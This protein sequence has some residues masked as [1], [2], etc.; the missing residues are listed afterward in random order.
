VEEIRGY[1]VGY[2]AN[3]VRHAGKRDQEPELA[4]QKHRTSQTQGYFDRPMAELRA[5]ARRQLQVEALTW[6]GMPADLAEREV[7]FRAEQTWQLVRRNPV[8]A[9]SPAGGDLEQLLGELV[10][11]EARSDGKSLS[12]REAAT[13]SPP[14]PPPMPVEL[15]AAAAEGIRPSRAV[16]WVVGRASA[17]RAGWPPASP[18]PMSAVPR[19]GQDASTPPGASFCPLPLLEVPDVLAVPPPP[20]R[21]P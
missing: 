2:V 3:K 6:R 15:Y 11:A 20:P 8:A 7:Q 16:A 14:P 19:C 4:R 18:H 10:V 5:E 9:T 12:V 1:A 17:R 13:D 21:S